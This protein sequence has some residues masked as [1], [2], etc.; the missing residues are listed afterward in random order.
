VTLRI[1]V[2]DASL[3]SLDALKVEA[4]A[5]LIGPER[6][7]RGLAG[8]ADW[9]LCGALSNAIRSG[10]FAPEMEEALLLPSSGRFPPGRI[11]CFGLPAAPLGAGGFA[12]AARRALGALARAHCRSFATSL[13]VLPEVP[14]ARLWLEE[15]LR[16]PVE[17]EVILGEAR[18]LRRDLEAARQALLADAE[19]SAF[20][21]HPEAAGAALPPRSAVVR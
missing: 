19:I 5:L 21:P 13:P 16:H 14:V 12:A 10:H 3:A 18:A 8:L 15:S 20:L 9:R 7:L 4:L 17:A 1:E 2:G 6:P 11:F